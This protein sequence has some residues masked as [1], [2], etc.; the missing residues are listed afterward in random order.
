MY[1]SLFF[2]AGFSCNL[3]QEAP[4]SRAPPPR[5]SRLHELLR[6][7]VCSR[8]RRHAGVRG[9]PVPADE[10]A[11]EERAAGPQR[12]AAEQLRH[13]GRVRAAVPAKPHRPEPRRRHTGR[14]LQRR[15]AAAG[16]ARGVQSDPLLAPGKCDWTLDASRTVIGSR[17]SAP[18]KVRLFTFFFHLFPPDKVC[19][20]TEHKARQQRG[21]Q[22]G[23]ALCGCPQMCR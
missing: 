18:P 20:G 11:A 8:A 1:S 6:A 21:S 2:F 3:Q 5:P 23:H 12:G 22:G 15:G 16:A 9:G 7:A 14:L 17:E 4:L 19:F 10:G 13:Q